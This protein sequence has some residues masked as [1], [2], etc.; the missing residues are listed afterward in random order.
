MTIEFYRVLAQWRNIWKA[1]SSPCVEMLSSCLERFTGQTHFVYQPQNRNSNKTCRVSRKAE[2][3]AK[4]QGHLKKRNGGEEKKER[5]TLQYPVIFDQLQDHGWVGGC[6]E[7][8]VLLSEAISSKWRTDSC[9]QQSW[10]WGHCRKDS[11]QQHITYHPACKLKPL[12]NC[13]SLL[14]SSRQLCCLWI[15]GGSL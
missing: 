1:C 5:K 13:S 8:A 4:N 11:R 14:I 6:E 15:S 9:K 3:E 12:S 7:W 2:W 10:V